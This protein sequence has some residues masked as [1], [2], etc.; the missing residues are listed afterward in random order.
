MQTTTKTTALALA[1]LALAASA[2]ANATPADRVEMA[3]GIAYREMAGLRARVWR[4]ERLNNNRRAIA[5]RHFLAADSMAEVEALRNRARQAGPGAIAEVER[6]ID[7]A[8]Q[9]ADLTRDAYWDAAE[10]S[11]RREWNAFVQ[12]VS[13]TAF[14]SARGMADA[15]GRHQGARDFHL[16]MRGRF[17]FNISGNAA[18]ENWLEE[19]IASATTVATGDTT[20]VDT[21]IGDTTAVTIVAPDS[22]NVEGDG[23]PGTFTVLPT[24]G[25]LGQGDTPLAGGDDTP[26]VVDGRPAINNAEL[27]TVNG[28]QGVTP[29]PVPADGSD[30]DS[31][32]V[33]TGWRTLTVQRNQTLG[34][35]ANQ[36]R[37]EIP[38]DV[39]PPLWGEGGMVDLLHQANAGHI[40]DPNVLAIG[41]IVRVPTEAWFTM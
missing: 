37:R 38:R 35:L 30:N 10:Q 18:S 3:R 27:D 4:S 20:P 16:F 15:F 41:D 7:R 31:N 29:P 25:F 9:V 6:R 11:F 34:E 33:D 17:I 2:Q 8:R 40:A 23:T 12:D 5:V 14:T 13:A 28:N 26:V 36:I 24:G 32:N 21:G 22:G 1:A 19:Y 39:R